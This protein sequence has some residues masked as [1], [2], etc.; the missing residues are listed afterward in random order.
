VLLTVAA[1]A[2]LLVVR[3]V[4]QLLMAPSRARVRRR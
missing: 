4:F 1:W 2:A 3:Y